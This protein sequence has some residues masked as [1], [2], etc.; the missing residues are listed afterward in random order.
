MCGNCAKRH[1]LTTPNFVGGTE[2]YELDVVSQDMSKKCPSCRAINHKTILV[3]PGSDINERLVRSLQKKAISLQKQLSEAS[4]DAAYQLSEAQSKAE[5]Q[6]SE[7]LG[8]LE[9]ATRQLSD[10]RAQA[11][12]D[13]EDSAQ[14]LFDTKKKLYDELTWLKKKLRAEQPSAKQWRRLNASPSNP[15]PSNPQ[16]NICR[17]W[18]RTGNCT[19]F[20]HTGWKCVFDHPPHTHSPSHHRR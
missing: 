5:F 6:L 18:K 4:V 19:Y 7:V 8:E 13:R 16:Q 10:A 11:A 1:V 17:H 14:N 9:D 2:A 3:T 20:E 15:P 12:S